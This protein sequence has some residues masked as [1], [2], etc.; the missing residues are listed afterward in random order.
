VKIGDDLIRRFEEPGDDILRTKY[1][2]GDKDVSGRMV[3][4]IAR[5]WRNFTE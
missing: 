3:K 1:T 2:C 4:Y 5:K